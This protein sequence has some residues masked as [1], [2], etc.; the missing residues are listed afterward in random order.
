[1]SHSL[2][3]FN[4]PIC[5]EEIC[6][7][8]ICATVSELVHCLRQSNIFLDRQ[9][10]AGCDCAYRW[11]QSGKPFTAAAF[12]ESAALTTSRGYMAA[13]SIVP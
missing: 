5:D 13:L 7:P 11:L 9:Q 8:Y 3:L 12:I 10:K 2:P 1:M 4:T 6:R